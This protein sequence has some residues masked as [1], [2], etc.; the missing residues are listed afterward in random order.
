MLFRSALEYYGFIVRKVYK[1]MGFSIKVLREFMLA[2]NDFA[3]FGDDRYS[4][5][6]NKLYQIFDFALYKHYTDDSEA[7]NRL[8]EKLRASLSEADKAN[9]Y[10]KEAVA[11]APAIKA[12][13][14]NVT[15]QLDKVISKRIKELSLDD[16]TKAIIEEEISKQQIKNQ[17]VSTFTE[18]VYLV[19][20][21][22]DGKE[23]NDLLTTLIHQFENIAGFVQ[24]MNENGISCEFKK[25]Y[26]FFEKS[27]TIAE[28]IRLVNSFARMTKIEADAKGV[29]FYEAALV[30]G[31]DWDHDRI[32]EELKLAEK[33]EKGEKNKHGFRNFIINNVI[34]SRKFHYL[35]RYANINNVRK[36]AENESLVK[37]VLGTLPETQIARYAENCGIMSGN[38]IN[39]LTKEI[40]GLKFDDFKDVNQASKAEKGNDKAV[41]QAKIGLYLTVLYLLTKNLVNVNSRYFMAFHCLERDSQLKGGKYNSSHGHFVNMT[42]LYV[43]ER[44][45][46][47]QNRFDASEKRYS[48]KKRYHEA[49][50]VYDYVKTD[51][52]N[53]DNAAR[54][55]FRNDI[56]HL[57]VIRNAADNIGNGKFKSYYQLYHYLMQ[58]DIVARYNNRLG[59]KAPNQSTLQYFD[60][61]NKF[62]RYSKDF[63]KA[64]CVP[65]A[66][67]LPRFKNLS[68]EELFDKNNKPETGAKKQ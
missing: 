40:V 15:P 56:A 27:G 5:V 17:Q 51:I 4:T 29:M 2:N 10:A 28:E 30:L 24:T 36:L 18:L 44:M 39:V 32:A 23:I 49:E 3:I 20:Q 48:D 6:R 16:N 35:V 13:L 45:Q 66:Y 14:K 52:A 7:A 38:P 60:E 19:T 12:V 11:I 50:R 59:D 54:N 55:L 1:N 8:I 65:F 22:I 42:G 61:I 41:K 63:V 21:V 47:A 57:T 53:T 68:V 33:T 43:E 64:L 34:K 31:T 67:N 26:A 9:V 46:K 58:K 25:E 62:N 37:L